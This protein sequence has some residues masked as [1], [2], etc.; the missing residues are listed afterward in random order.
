MLAIWMV[1]VSDH[2]C[3]F[4]KY[5]SQSFISI[6]FS[7]SLFSDPHMLQW[8]MC[9]RLRLVMYNTKHQMKV[10]RASQLSISWAILFLGIS[11]QLAKQSHIWPWATVRVAAISMEVLHNNEIKFPN[12]EVRTVQYQGC[13]AEWKKW[14]TTR[15]K[16]YIRTHSDKIVLGRQLDRPEVEIQLC[17]VT[18]PYASWLLNISKL[19]QPHIW[20]GENDT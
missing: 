7:C 20:N 10:L 17:L 3:P 2:H 6:D 1:R 8:R 4:L 16:P 18:Q 5:A 14:L 15:N 13:S 9:K 19:W 11:S 12:R